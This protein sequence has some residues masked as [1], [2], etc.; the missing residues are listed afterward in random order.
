MDPKILQVAASGSKEDL[1]QFNL[2]TVCS[3]RDTKGN[4]ALLLAAG[5]PDIGCLQ[6]LLSQ[7]SSKRLLFHLKN[8]DGEGAL[9]VAAQ[10]DQHEHL[11]LLL[12]E[13]MSSVEEKTVSGETPLYQAF[14]RKS[15]RASKVLLQNG[16]DP[17]ACAH[18]GMSALCLILTDSSE[19]KELR[20]MVIQAGH[21]SI[22]MDDCAKKGTSALLV[23][24]MSRPESKEARNETWLENA[25]ESDNK[26]VAETLINMGVVNVNLPKSKHNPLTLSIL[27]GRDEAARQLLAHGALDGVDGDDTFPTLAAVV[28]EN[29]DILRLLL[30]RE[31]K[32]SHGNSSALQGAVDAGHE[33][34]LALLLKAGEPVSGLDLDMCLG[35]IRPKLLAAGWPPNKGLDISTYEQRRFM[36]EL[37]ADTERTLTSLIDLARNA[38]RESVDIGTTNI[39]HVVQVMHLPTF[40]QDILLLGLTMDSF[41]S[42]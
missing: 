27:R 4:N 9:H 34:C 19:H 35:R 30:D 5:N 29:D 33:R 18:F 38:F 15:L 6:F 25:L 10:A 1:S 12:K 11:T 8:D 17:A 20:E 37:E 3:A 22:L 14:S 26:D 24:L 7:A 39:V 42:A 23:S 21:L 32:T 36:G 13:E 40:V 31:F 41:S 28:T 2:R 16:A